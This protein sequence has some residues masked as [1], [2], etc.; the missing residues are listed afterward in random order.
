M[1][2]FQDTIFEKFALCITCLF[3]VVILSITANFYFDIR[4]R[5][6]LMLSK[7]K[8]ADYPDY[9]CKYKFIRFLYECAFWTFFFT[10]IITF[11]LHAYIKLT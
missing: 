9:L 1:T 6:V 3:V 8:E 11:S 2:L 4:A 5:T 10:I 7:D